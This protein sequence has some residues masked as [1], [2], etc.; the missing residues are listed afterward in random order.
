M[1]NPCPA[2]KQLHMYTCIMIEL[3]NYALTD[4]SRSV[5]EL[6]KATMAQK[7]EDYPE[8]RDV[9]KMYVAVSDPHQMP[10]ALCK[11][12][13]TDKYVDDVNEIITEIM[14]VETPEKLVE[15]FESLTSLT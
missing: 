4:K 2:L 7:V 14:L 10:I 8:A 15:S 11:T 9:V 13:Y 1:A 12:Q 5:F 6:C 3:R